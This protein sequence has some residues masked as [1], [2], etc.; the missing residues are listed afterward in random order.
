MQTEF[1][2][3]MKPHL[4]PVSGNHSLLHA[5]CSGLLAFSCFTSQASGQTGPCSGHMRRRGIRTR[6]KGLLFF[7]PCYNQ[8]KYIFSR[9]LSIDM[10]SGV[11]S[12]LFPVKINI[13]S[14]VSKTSSAKIRVEK[15]KNKYN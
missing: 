6:G 4:D 12:V 5:L 11:N 8:G 2:D 14:P 9:A 3:T 10:V 1:L 7:P 13:S 15:L